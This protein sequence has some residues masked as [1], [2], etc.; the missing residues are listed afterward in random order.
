MPG[1]LGFDYARA[2]AFMYASFDYFTTATDDDLGYPADGN[3]L[4]QR[5]AWYSLNDDDFEGSPS[6]HHLFDPG[7]AITPLGIDYG[8]YVSLSID[9]IS[10]CVTLTCTRTV[11]IKAEARAG[12]D[13]AEIHLDFDPV[14]LQVVNVIGGNEAG[15]P[16][17]TVSQNAFNNETGRIDYTAQTPEGDPATGSFIVA[18][19][20]FTAL[21]QTTAT[22]IQ[23]LASTELFRDGVPV[24]DT[25]TDGNVAVGIFGDFNCDCIVDV[26][27]IMEVADRWRCRSEDEC[28]DPCYDVD[29]DGDIDIVDIMLVVVHWGDA[30]ES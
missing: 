29:G 14:Y 22:T 19:I 28:Y 26:V 12:V 11:E 18:R 3:R 7:G 8:N 20:Q 5:W 27:D 2:K 1:W 16:L 17:T 23:F 4:V 21:A 10:T 15:S 24:L 6:H 13:T 25:H 30:C 9:P